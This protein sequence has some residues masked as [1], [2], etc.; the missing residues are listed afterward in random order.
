MPKAVAA[1]VGVAVVLGAAVIWAPSAG[2]RTTVEV[3][4]DVVTITVPIDVMNAPPE[5]S[6]IYASGDY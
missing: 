1:L 5:P 6:T 3:N 2:A 4:D